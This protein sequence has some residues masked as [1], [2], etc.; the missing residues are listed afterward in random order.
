MM[1]GHLFQSDTTL[2][3]FASIQTHRDKDPHTHTHT[4]NCFQNN[5][6][7]SRV[8]PSH[9]PLLHAHCTRL[10]VGFA[11]CLLDPTHTTDLPFD[12]YVAVIAVY[13]CADTWTHTA[14]INVT[15]LLYLLR[16]NPSQSYLS[17]CFPE[18]FN[19]FSFFNLL[20][21]LISMH[22]CWAVSSFYAVSLCLIGGL[23][24]DAVVQ[25]LTS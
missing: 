23:A 20:N 8:P 9:F 16:L 22:L 10:H 15:R 3:I 14:S 12:F 25:T 19:V 5:C 6:P 17:V 1:F 24:S 13:P 2:A 18:Y 11:C 21:V 7:C 4:L